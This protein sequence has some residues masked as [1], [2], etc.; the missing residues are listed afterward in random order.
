MLCQGYVSRWNWGQFSLWQVYRIIVCGLTSCLPWQVLLQVFLAKRRV[1]RYVHSN[2]LLFLVQ[3]SLWQVSF[4]CNAG[5]LE[6][7]FRPP[8]ADL[9]EYVRGLFLA[10]GLLMDDLR[11]EEAYFGFFEGCVYS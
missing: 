10:I 9:L 7:E 4:I 8:D 5:G 1:A 2:F 6:D 11:V 3:V